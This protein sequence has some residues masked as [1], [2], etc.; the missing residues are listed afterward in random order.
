MD[1]MSSLMG[2]ELAREI[3]RDRLAEAEARRTAHLVRPT[4]LARLSQ[5]VKTLVPAPFL[6][7]G[8]A[9]AMAPSAPMG[10]TA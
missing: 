5:R 1:K 9:R 4:L 2:M 6:Q 10:C 8:R 3:S 7:V